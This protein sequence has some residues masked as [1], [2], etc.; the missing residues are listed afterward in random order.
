[1]TTNYEKIKTMNID[2]MA[3]FLVDRCSFCVFYKDDNCWEQDC[4]VGHKQWLNQE[5]E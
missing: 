1:M 2:E 4:L 3:E 5:V